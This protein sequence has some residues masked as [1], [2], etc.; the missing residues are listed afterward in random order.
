MASNPFLEE[1]RRRD[2]R[3]GQIPTGGQRQAPAADG[4]QGN[5]LNN[6]FGRNLA[7]LPSAGGIPGAALR[8]TGLVARAFGASQPAMSGL[9]QA[10]QAAASYAPVVGGG[11]W[12]HAGFIES[13]VNHLAISPF[14]GL[15]FNSKNSVFFNRAGWVD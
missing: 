15:P 11:A 13:I 4:S 10:T 7:A 6:D 12:G 14:L 1:A 8:G 3:V 9:G 2:A 5:I